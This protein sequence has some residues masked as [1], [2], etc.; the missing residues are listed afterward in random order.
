M[1]LQLHLSHAV[2]NSFSDVGSRVQRHEC[3]QSVA[4][5]YGSTSTKLLQQVQSV[6]FDGGSTAA[7]ATQTTI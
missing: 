7:L 2:M 1:S 3:R 6:N 5:W 4:E